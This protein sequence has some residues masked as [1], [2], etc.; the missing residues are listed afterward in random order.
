[1][2]QA[3]PTPALLS[4]TANYP[5]LHLPSQPPRLPHETQIKN[6]FWKWYKYTA[7]KSY[8]PGTHAILLHMRVRPLCHGIS[9]K[10]PWVPGSNCP[11]VRHS[12]SLT[13]HFLCAR[14]CAGPVPMSSNLP[15]LK[16]A[17]SL[18]GHVRK[19]GNISFQI[20]SFKLH[21]QEPLYPIWFKLGRVK[22][23]FYFPR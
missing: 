12:T 19:A 18:G 23:R 16:P 7:G 1:M 11:G 14:N 2:G 5:K 15:L 21:H 20:S 8:F 3:T 17:K 4:L 10:T 9:M 22:W 6:E 13:E